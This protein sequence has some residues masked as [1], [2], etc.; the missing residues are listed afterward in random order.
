MVSLDSLHTFVAA[1]R[2]GSLT[3]AAAHLRLSQPAVSAQLRNLERDLGEPLLVR[4]PRGVV[5]TARGDALARRLAPHLDAL[6]HALGGETGESDTEPPVLHLGG[7]SD[8]IAGWAVEPI[9]ALLSAGVSVRV[10]VGTAYEL[11]TSSST[12]ASTW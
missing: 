4:G 5:P 6:A 11:P 3:R 1:Y 7:P 10:S 12:P 9:A 8:F 2:L